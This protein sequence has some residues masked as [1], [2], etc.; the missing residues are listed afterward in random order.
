MPMIVNGKMLQVAAS[1]GGCLYPD[2]AGDKQQ[3]LRRADLAMY[4]VKRTE[5][6]GWRWYGR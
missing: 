3:L 5:K 4:Q 6:D 2:Q 1:V